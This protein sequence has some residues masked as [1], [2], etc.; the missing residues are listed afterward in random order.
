VGGGYVRDSS[1]LLPYM[2]QD[3]T[4]V[5]RIGSKC[6]NLQ[7]HLVGTPP[8]SSSFHPESRPFFINLGIFF[9]KYIYLCMCVCV[10]ERERLGKIFNTS[11]PVKNYL[12]QSVRSTMAGKL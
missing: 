11:T 3:Q 1:P 4:Q 5:D 9:Y 7:R 6:L 12:S 8:N 10:S 2:S